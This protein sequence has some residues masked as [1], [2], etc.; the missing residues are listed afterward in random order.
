[1]HVWI[2]SS[3]PTS[4][5]AIL[6]HAGLQDYCRFFIT[7]M[8]S[9][10]ETNHISDSSSYN[11]FSTRMNVPSSL[12][13][14]NSIGSPPTNTFMGPFIRC[15]RPTNLLLSTMLS[16]LSLLLLVKVTLSNSFMMSFLG[17]TGYSPWK[18][19]SPPFAYLNK[20]KFLLLLLLPSWEFMQLRY[21]IF[22][23]L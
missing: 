3:L 11:S 15:H 5:P 1:M 8:N 23:V 22:R 20:K 12:C 21:H 4:T 2:S 9:F 18:F 19:L 16:L 7:T 6:L 14:P 13:V 17:M 10:W